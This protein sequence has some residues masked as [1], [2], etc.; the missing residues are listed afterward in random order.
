MFLHWAFSH[1]FKLIVPPNLEKGL[2][3]IDDILFVFFSMIYVYLCWDML[4]AFIP[5]LRPTYSVKQD[6]GT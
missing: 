2:L 3:W 6:T 5:A 1:A 4:I